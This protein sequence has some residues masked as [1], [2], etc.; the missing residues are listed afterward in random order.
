V[1]RTQGDPTTCGFIG[2][3]VEYEAAKAHGR[4]LQMKDAGCLSAVSGEAYAGLK[5]ESASL[6]LQCGS[7]NSS[8][9]VFLMY[10]SCL[11]IDVMWK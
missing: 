7:E 1:I 6:L 3:E 2:F 4:Q 11:N 8:A 10:G 9:L 5:E